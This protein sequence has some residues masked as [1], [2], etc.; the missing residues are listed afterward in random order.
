ML[1]IAGGVLPAETIVWMTDR[2][3]EEFG[4]YGLPFSGLWGRPLQLIDVQNLL[5]EVSKYTRATHPAI[6]GRS[7]RIRIKQRFTSAGAFPR[8]F[9]PPKW[10]LNRRI[11]DW[12][13]NGGTTGG[14]S[15][16]VQS[17]LPLPNSDSA[18]R[19][20]DGG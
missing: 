5:C 9:F 8:P 19:S 15:Q 20:G 7:G 6:K 18:T 16:A 1:R 3:D 13:G 17:V 14:W 2:Q 12:L 10:G 11:E 4:R